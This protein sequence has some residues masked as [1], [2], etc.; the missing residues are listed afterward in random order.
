[1]ESDEPASEDGRRRL[2]I[3]EIGQAVKQVRNSRGWSLRR[4]A[5]EAG[6]SASLLSAVETGKIVPTIGSLFAISDALGERTETFFP[7]RR[8]PILAQQPIPD[9]ELSIPKPAEV[10]TSTDTSTNAGPGPAASDEGEPHETAP[11]S[12]TDR[13]WSPDPISVHPAPVGSVDETSRPLLSARRPRRAPRRPSLK[14]IGQV[15]P[16]AR[17]TGSNP[18]DSPTRL[19]GSRV[20]SGGPRSPAGVTIRRAGERPGIVLEDGT[21]WSLP[22]ESLDA[23]GQVIEVAIPAALTPPPRHRVRDRAMTVLVTEGRLRIDAAFVETVLEIGDSADISARVPYR[24]VGSRELRTTYL[25][26]VAGEW[27]GTL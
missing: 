27:D 20:A 13:E 14:S 7:I 17:I 24:L 5:E 16:K 19:T 12:P 25:A 10:G 4:L 26:F 21:T 11:I 15:E 23:I 6:V 2:E 8:R 9:G 1:M 3:K 22:V 18:A